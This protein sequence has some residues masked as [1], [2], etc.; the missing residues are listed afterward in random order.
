MVL[1]A[2]ALAAAE[3]QGVGKATPFQ[4][5]H[6]HIDFVGMRYKS[7][8]FLFFVLACSCTDELSR[9]DCSLVLCATN[10][11]IQL[12]I[13][14]NGTN[15]LASGGITTEDVTVT[16]SSEEQVWHAVYNNTHCAV[17]SLLT[18][19]LFAQRAAPYSYSIDI[20]SSIIFDIEVVYELSGEDP[21]CG[22]RLLI[23][24]LTS[25]DVAVTAMPGHFR[26]E[27]E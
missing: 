18:I 13:L 14:Q 25:M 6:L 17:E 2:E 16:S 9:P 26:I 22:Q 19:S 21:C 24:E 27:L 20:Q 7:F 12:E 5:R 1:A 23:R 4:I 11:T 8:Y 15:I 3:L 10:E